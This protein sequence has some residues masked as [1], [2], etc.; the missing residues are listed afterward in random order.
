M[1]KKEGYVQI[2]EESK[3]LQTL[4][5][6]K[7]AA[8]GLLVAMGVTATLGY[9]A[10][11]CGWVKE[12]FWLD[13]VRAGARAGVVG[14]IADWFAVVALFRHPLGIPI[15]HTAIIP[16]QK[17]RLASAL[18]RFVS[19]QVLTS[20][21]INLI[22]EKM[23]IPST[24]ANCIEDRKTRAVITQNI[25]GFLPRILDRLKDGTA[26]N[27]LS[28]VLPDVMS[29]KTLAPFMI[30]ALRSLVD[31]NQHQEVLSYL[32]AQLKDLLRSKEGMLRDIIEERVREQGG[33]FLGWAIGGGV[34]TRVLAAASDELERVDPQ[35][36][37]LREGFTQWVRA[38]IDHLEDD[39][40]SA[41]DFFDAALGVFSHESITGWGND[42]W[43][44][45]RKMV[46]EDMENPQGKTACF[47][48][49]T[50]DNIIL[51]LRHNQQLQHY[52]TARFEQA[53]DKMLPFLRQQVENFII[54][55]ISRWDA[56]EI[57]EKLEL[58]VG[59][60]MQFIRFNGTAVGFIIGA[61]LFVFM[62][63][64]FGIDT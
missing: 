58:R 51:Q 15:P 42:L 1:E 26:S 7:S 49:E 57:S 23:D 16:S 46:E 32:I 9:V 39:S 48:E 19:Q 14:G 52:V 56:Q 55:I 3:E 22:V 30:K 4:R 20:K 13:M 63:L 62:H 29:E 12:G 54:K 5:H 10:P 37:E 64:L 27:F 40:D 38:Q 2:K 61:L 21:E 50:L 18:G 35:N 34:A 8:T 47:V 33:K 11:Q 60:D 44:K 28:R 53:I 31:N 25:M 6:Y 43:V 24:L 59:R 17:Q 45:F 41:R 36:S